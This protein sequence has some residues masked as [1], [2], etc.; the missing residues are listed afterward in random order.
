M[1]DISTSISTN[2]S[3]VQTELF[4]PSLQYPSHPYAEI[5]AQ[6]AERFPENEAVIFSAPIR[7]ANDASASDLRQIANDASASSYRSGN[8]QGVRF[9]QA[10]RKER[11]V[12]LTYRE[13]DALV[14]SFANALLDLG[15]R[16]GDRV[17]LLMTNRPEFLVSWFALARIGAVISPMNPSYKEREVAYQLSNSDA[18]AIVAQHGLLPMVQ[19]VHAQT[20]GLEHIIVVGGGQQALPPW[21]HSFGQLVRT[22]APTTPKS[23]TPAWEELLTLPYSSGTTGLPK[24]VMLSHKNVVCNARQSLATARI[25]PQD[26]ML[27]FVPLYHIYGIMLIGTASM[28][29]ATMVLME[30]FEP[31]RCLQLI[32]EQRITL[33]YSVPQVLAVLSD[34]PQLKEYDLSSVRYTQCG[35]APVPPALA[36]RFQERTNITVMTSY[37]LTEAAPGTHSNPVYDRRL[38]KVETIGLPIHDTQQKIVDLETGQIELGVGEVGELIVKGPQVMQGYWKAPEATAEALRDGWLYTGD[39][40]WRDEEGYVTITDRKKE[41]IKYKGFSVAP[42][43]IEALLLEHP[44]VAD[45]GVIAKPSEEAGEVPK[46]F[47]VLRAGYEQLNTDE[48]MVWANGKLAAYK[49]VHEIE[50]IDA[51]PRNPSG[52]ILRR[53]LKDLEQ[54][55]M[56]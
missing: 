53:V 43:Q 3:H 7:L 39:I 41:M 28:S 4:R 47:V 21:V 18:V 33:L 10:R 35:A 36:Y 54:Q 44:A 27:V 52:K 34:W 12:N 15:V 42:A 46:A 11:D 5:L 40:G 26:R 49:N 2:R 17:C 9:A 20:P 38:I 25:T 56:G 23:P 16:K 24:G 45:V 51:I 32:Q 37:G 19:A 31:E 8:L 48:L 13:L 55:K 30:R 1:T 22:H 6:A 29:G 14:N 50:L